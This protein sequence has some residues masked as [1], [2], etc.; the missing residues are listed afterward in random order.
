MR[1]IFGTEE[2]FRNYVRQQAA[3]AR[4]NAQVQKRSNRVMQK[5]ETLLQK[6]L[7]DIKTLLGAEPDNAAAKAAQTLTETQL[8]DLRQIYFCLLYTSPSPRDTR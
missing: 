3:E 2:D 7:T 5:I 1:S 8:K 6:V 4:M